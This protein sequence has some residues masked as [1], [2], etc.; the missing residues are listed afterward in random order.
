MPAPTSVRLADR[1]SLAQ[2]VK[3]KLAEFNRTARDDAEFRR[4]TLEYFKPE[5]PIE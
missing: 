5:V 3:G 4:L 1:L 2:H